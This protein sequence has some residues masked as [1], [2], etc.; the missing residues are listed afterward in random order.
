MKI[1]EKLYL[2]KFNRQDDLFNLVRAEHGAMRMANE[3]G[4][5]TANTCIHETA[6]HFVGFR[7]LALT[8]RAG[9]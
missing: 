7:V 6:S 1:G 8:L 2:A 9:L 4:I 3:L 5:R